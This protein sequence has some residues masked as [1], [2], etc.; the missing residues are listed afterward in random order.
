MSVAIISVQH[1]RLTDILMPSTRG[2]GGRS[3]RGGRREEKREGERRRGVEE[4]FISEV[5]S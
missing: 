2:N 5:Q 1:Y 3:G 4:I